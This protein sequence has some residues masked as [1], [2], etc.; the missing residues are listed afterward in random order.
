P[1]GD[2]L[3]LARRRWVAQ[4]TGGV[5]AMGYAGY[6]RSDAVVLRLLRRGPLSIGRL[7]EALGVTRQAAR[8]TAEGLARRGFATVERD[9]HDSRQINVALN[10]GGEAYCEAI[11][12]VIDR[13]NGDLV[14]QVDPADLDGCD[15]VLR[16][17]LGG[18]HDRWLAATLPGPPPRAA[19]AHA[20]SQRRT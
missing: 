2:L 5:E 16:A 19:P 7:G 6:R 14:R 4:M 8:K 1:F 3:A 10:A 12:T 20:R 18:E 15:A 13:L 11:V 9:E 17:V